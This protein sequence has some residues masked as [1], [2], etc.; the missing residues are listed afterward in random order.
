[1]RR[2]AIA[3][4]KL[5]GIEAAYLAGLAGWESVLIDK[6]KNP[7]AAGLCSSFYNLDIIRDSFYLDRILRG[8]ELIIP[9]VEDITVLNA[10]YRLSQEVKTP[11]AY[12]VKAYYISR[13]KKLSSH[14]FKKSG[15]LQPEGWTDC[16]LPVI[17]KPSVSSGSRGVLKISNKN[18][19][20]AFIKQAGRGLKGWILQKYI[21]GPS[22][23]IEVLG[24]NGNYTAIQVTELGMDSHY[25]C[26]R[27]LAPADIP[28][29]LDKQI[30]EIAINIACRLDLKG[31]MDVE[32]ILDKEVL[33]ILE[34]DARLPSQTP[35]AV[36]KSTG[37]NMLE[38]IADIFIKGNLP[39][40]PEIKILS[41]VVYE[42][43][44]VCQNKI[45]FPGEHVLGQAE[46]LKTVS[47]FFGAD[48]AITNFN[49]SSFSWVATLIST[50]KTRQQ[51]LLKS[52]KV[53]E[54]IRSYI[55]KPYRF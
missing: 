29:S 44:K 22:Y 40:F 18:K 50:G 33:K 34:I 43:I 5:Q 12:D 42:H 14:L 53:I 55:E 47:G 25:D 6:K 38:L 46:S 20:D 26:N 49:A 35:A 41:G 45:E 54:N 7:P 27:V 39:K 9:A 32:F 4:G 2:I 16:G 28:E 31:I 52:Q 48:E 23:S 19:L 36:Y 15:I 24:L 10:L 11:L 3:G 51:A 21:E 13:S 37:I 30:K 17:A 1:M 8:V